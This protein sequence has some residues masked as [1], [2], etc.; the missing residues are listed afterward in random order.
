ML[1]G[2][3]THT[4]IQEKI[5]PWLKTKLI[6]KSALIIENIHGE[7]EYSVSLMEVELS[8]NVKINAYAIKQEFSFM[9]P[10]KKLIQYLWP[11][12]DSHIL[13]E[14]LH[15]AY[16]GET[17]LIIGQD[18]YWALMDNSVGLENL[19]T[20]NNMQ[21]GIIRTK[22]GWSISG[23]LSNNPG[24]PQAL[25]NNPIKT[26]CNMEKVED[27]E[28]SLTKLFN[29]DEDLNNE[30]SLSS[31][32]QYAV[33]RFKETIRRQPDGRYTVQPIFKKDA[34][35]LKNNYFLAN[36]RYR[37]LMK[38]LRRYPERLQAYNEAM[39]KMLQNQEIEEVKETKE[40]CQNPRRNLYHLPHS[41]VVKEERLTTNVRVVFDGSAENNDGISLN[42]QLLE[43]PALQ[44]DIAAL[45][46]LLRLKKYV[47][48][49]D[50]SRMFYNI[51]LQEE[52]RDYYRFLWN[53]D[54]DAEE[55]KVYRFRSIT[56][57]AKDSPF[58]A[59]ATIHYHL[60]HVAQRNPEKRWILELLRKHLY[61][62]DLILSVDTIEEA[63]LVRKEITDILGEMKMK[64]RKWASN[65]DKI[66]NTIPPEDRYPTLDDSDNLISKDTKCLGVSWS[67]SKDMLHYNSY[68]TLMAKKKPKFTKRGISSI[69]PAL[70]DPAG[71]I[72]P[73]IVE[74]KICLQK[75][76]TY[77]D[78]K[79][80]SLGWDDFLP[81]DL[82][83][84]FD[85]W[86]N[87]LE[88]ISLAAYPRYL[89]P[90]LK[91]TPKPE[92][93]YLHIFCDAGENCYGITAYIRYV[94][95]DTGVFYSKLI[96][97]CSRTAPSKNRLTI[98]KK[99]LCSILL[100]NQ[101]GEYLRNIINI[102][103]DN[104]FVHS[105]SMVALFWCMQNPEKLKIYVSNR[106]KKIKEIN[107]TLLYVPGIDNPADYTTKIT[108]WHKYLNTSF[109]QTGPEL[110]REDTESILSK[111]CIEYIKDSS[112]LS[113]KEVEEAQAE[114][115]P[116][117]TKL[118][119]Y[120]ARESLNSIHHILQRKSN[121]HKILRITCYFLK[122]L[123]KCISG[124]GNENLKNRLNQ[125]YFT[126]EFLNTPT[127]QYLGTFNAEQL[128]KAAYF[129]IREAQNRKFSEE[130]KNL[131]NKEGSLKSSKLDKLNPYLDS[132]S[133]LR[134]NSRLEY[135]HL[136]PEQMT[137][138]IILPDNE[139]ITELIVLDYHKKLSH[140][141]PEVTL[142]EVKLTYWIIGGRREI[143]KCI[144]TCPNR[145][146]KYQNLIEVKQMEAKLPVERGYTGNFDRV[147]LDYAG[148]FEI[149]DC[150]KC[151]FQK[152]KKCTKCG[153]K[154][155]KEI[156]E[157]GICKTRKVWIL[158]IACH[159]SRGVHLELVNDKTTEEFVLAM[160]RFCNRRSTPKSIHSD[161]AGEFIQGKNIITNVFD[162][163][164]TYKT[165]QKLQ[166][167][168]S[169]TW[170][171]SPSRAPHHSGVIE[172]IVGTIKKPLIK[173]L[174][175]SILTETE[176]YTILTDVEASVNSRPLAKLSE[177]A[178]DGNISCITP[179]HL[180][181]GKS[182]RPIPNEIYKHIEE[183]RKN[184]DIVK[185]WKLR[186]KLT[187]LF[188]KRWTR[189]YLSELRQYHNEI[190]S[191]A[192]LKKGDYCLATSEKVGKYDWP[193]AVV[194]EVFKGRD[195]LVRTVELKV[196][197][198]ANEINNK[199]QPLKQYKTI[200]RGIESITLL[201]ASK[202]ETAI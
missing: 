112:N 150:G 102:S 192:N 71:L 110:L 128:K 8:H 191:R 40:D 186:N 106:V 34:V 121:Y 190:Q 72:Q 68:N 189:E 114:T 70:Y 137:K 100:G 126:Q 194:K 154:P 4:M 55:P 146:C 21:S 7:E 157:N 123:S 198:P 105:D 62:D 159:N 181:L 174:Q 130:I 59:I 52:F 67:P 179:N 9:E 149:K 54:T 31:E 103:A 151:K 5:L 101:K 3:A 17:H 23:N 19:I 91:G 58:I 63:I 87:Q 108:P 138:P 184:V 45:Q 195:G 80:N 156:K 109:W 119:T 16:E 39:Q 41:A 26:I 107:F 177:N 12:L 96:Y 104:T 89:F 94:D 187:D 24:W 84:M 162:D 173:T 172:R 196:K 165:H 81:K 133:I 140:G 136:Y 47:I 135:H 60:D 131:Q 27:I 111:Y 145:H 178:D 166:D 197:Q 15:N 118:F 125:H 78:N 33:D 42:S 95:N 175:G 29:R 169:I 77:R 180:I 93:I 46:I 116:L 200:R 22:F 155:N 185:R 18:N 43:G 11:N 201:E 44:Q 161:N 115:K 56:M 69:V 143:R 50:I 141:G 176:F 183:P 182:L 153:H 90:E 168:L 88:N 82:E 124:L 134:M 127:N 99:E 171:H 144:K 79:G 152:D 28:E 14:I 188:W 66:L 65:N 147:A 1:D 202:E 20:H 25:S 61:V 85:K 49:G 57:G 73:Y 13:E 74:G 35:P 64:I 170:Y 164:N 83:T 117:K 163:L 132:S 76:W 122:F 148:Y 30:S 75:A 129:H 2:C 38:S 6:R 51:Y 37:S 32:E 86:T 120:Q 10:N 139:K 113:N 142:R 158:V 97:A 48:I 98:P 193:T 53:F 199:G 92:D 167:E 160:K 36:I